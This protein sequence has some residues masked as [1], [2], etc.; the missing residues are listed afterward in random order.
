MHENL[1]LGSNG[2]NST[3][4]GLGGMILAAGLGTRLKPWTDNHP[5]ALALV[6]GK[7]L[8][9]HN[10]EYLQRYRIREIVVN[11]HHFANQIIEAI[12][13]NNGWGS[14]VIISHE[15][16]EV[17]ETGGGLLKA[18]PLL[19]GSNPIVLMNVDILTD[20]NLQAIINYHQEKKPLVTLATTNRETSRY[21][22]FDG[23]NN[24]CGW[25]N[26][27]TGEVRPPNLQKGKEKTARAFSGIHIVESRIFSLIKQLKKFSIVDVYIDLMQEQTIKSFDHSET[28]FIDVGKAESLSKAEILFKSS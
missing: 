26:I 2:S 15:K 11:V 19:E 4:R 8:L 24:L 23:G 17:L 28:R 25:K 21:F 16:E 22:L 6:N 5:K 27:K 1:V 12:E 20:L 9:Q 13:K 7:S 14:R 18:A 10:I 3:S